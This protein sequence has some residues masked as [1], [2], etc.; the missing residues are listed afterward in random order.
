VPP[1]SV[2]GEMVGLGFTVSVAAGEDV[3]GEPQV[4]LTTT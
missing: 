1:G 4:P 3:T 2:V